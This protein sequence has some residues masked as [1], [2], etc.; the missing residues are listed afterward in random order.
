M[1]QET[2][3]FIEK[4][5]LKISGHFIGYNITY[6]QLVK[7]LEEYYHYRRFPPCN[8]GVSEVRLINYEDIDKIP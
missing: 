5:D 3:D 2:K 7:M 8:G 6:T 4:Q 1:K